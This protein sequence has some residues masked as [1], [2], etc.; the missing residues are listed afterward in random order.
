[1]AASEEV[2]RPRNDLPWR[3]FVACILV[4]A[5]IAAI[6][7][8]LYRI[9]D[10]YARRQVDAQLLTIA[11]LKSSQIQQWRDERLSHASVLSDNLIFAATAARWLAVHDRVGEA[12]LRDYF[13]QLA[14]HY[15]YGN[16]F[17]VDA[18][19]E[20]RLSLHE[21]TESLPDDTRAL[22]ARALADGQPRHGE[23]HRD[24]GGGLPHM[25]F[26]APIRVQGDSGDA[27]GAV[28]LQADPYRF[29]YPLL[30]SW[31]TPSASSET[32][33]VRRD[34]DEVLF[35]NELRHAKN[36]A[37]RLRRPLSESTL[38]AAQAVLGREGIF[39]GRDHR[40]EAV[41]AAL[42]AVAGTD[43]FIV[44]KTDR[45][46]ALASGR[47][48]NA[49]I[50][51]L[52][53]GSM[54]GAVIL[55]LV[56]WQAS[57]KRHYRALFKSEAANRELRERFATAFQASPLATAI[58]TVAEGRFIDVNPR[59]EAAFGWPREA[60][61]GRSGVEVGLWPSEAARASWLTRWRRFGGSADIPATLLRRD[62]E[63]REVGIA[64]AIVSLGGVEH[65]IAYI[66]DLTERNRNLAELEQ[67]RHHLAELVEQRT[68]ELA[69]AKDEA[70]SA[71]RA[72]SVFLANMSHE[73]RTPM[74]A[75]IGLTHLALRDATQATQRERLQKIN[76]SAQHLLGVINDILDISKIEAEKLVL[77]ETD[78]E[79]ASI[80]E[81]AETLNQERI[82]EKGLQLSREIDPALP[83][84]L[85]G[86]PLR[87]GQILLNYLSNAIKFTAR[88]DIT[89]RARIDGE[90]GDAL[91]VR[92]E[93][94][95][96][97]SG[98]APD[99]LPRLF[100]SFE[101]ADSS[102]T[103]Q[104]GGT[105]LGLAICRRLARMMGGDTGVQS[106][107]G[108]GSTFWFT[109]RLRRGRVAVRVSGSGTQARA[110]ATLRQRARGLRVL[111]AED[112]LINQE[113]ARGLLEA[114]G[115]FVDIAGNGE[116]AVRLAAE[117]DYAAILMDVQMPVMD[118]FEATLAIRQL[119]GRERTAILAMTA[120]AFVEDRQM[121]LDAGM[122]AHLA[123][124]FNPDELY[125]LLLCWLPETSSL[126]APAPACHLA[127]GGESARIHLL[128]RVEGLDPAR[129]LHILRGREDSY[130]ALLRVFADNHADDMRP[131]RA[132]LAGDRR[133]E[134]RLIA[135][136]LKGSAGTLGLTLVEAIARDLE[137]RI[138]A[139]GSAGDLDATI[140]ECEA[141][142]LATAAALRSALPPP[143]NDAG[144][145][146]GAGAN[147]QFAAT[148]L[149]RLQN[150]LDNDSPEAL[151]IAREH[152]AL[153][154]ELTAT[155]WPQLQRQIRAFDLADAAAT[156]RE[157]CVELT[158]PDCAEAPAAGADGSGTRSG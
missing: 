8:V 27:A 125:A 95:D 55:F 35:L 69:Q 121:C 90:E 1:M 80:F 82:A 42:K 144:P 76:A 84:V 154:G 23:L 3:L 97:G 104:H 64:A 36:T 67:H 153:L 94:S 9:H 79:T 81:N 44:A 157:A 68:A 53:L 141:R 146:N 45:R 116:E 56:I 25:D 37:L 155:H 140:A 87:L 88:G 147:R 48:V 15:R 57:G 151:A 148:V 99:V 39:D 54:V 73:I 63:R 131:L 77:E 43:W 135:H 92:F 98:I 70:E 22:L 61:I 123:K 113:V 129:G 96:T 46:E 2:Q 150:A 118:G 75:V 32:L 5:A 40:G 132:A 72:K 65:L 145:Q 124:P 138:T 14:E 34:G 41:I 114:V 89:M 6:G 60:L 31:P 93:V 107:P 149:S 156:L 49:L 59:F 78:F 71:N 13:K 86:D 111:L 38:P 105:G 142:L 52:T 4:L 128:R 62:G 126:A 143:A 24:A 29:L 85:R 26:I 18:Q 50:V 120:N 16:V 110:E 158:L 47:L 20:V 108:E 117:Y 19:G 30:Q 102:T 7:T 58:S 21:M 130:L 115:L 91:I 10:A 122:N 100:R 119:P 12:R 33:L 136:S 74:N 127:P 28:I 134:A 17:L 11:D 112:N 51:A 139:G 152:A 106:A 83:S 137:H 109:A 103:R 66:G 133:D 101:Q